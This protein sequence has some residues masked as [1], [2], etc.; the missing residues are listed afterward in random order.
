MASYLAVSNEK[1]IFSS[2]L[3]SY[4]FPIITYSSF[5]KGISS[6]AWII[7]RY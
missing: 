7:D 4:L 2:N 5:I 6:V 3:M 1:I